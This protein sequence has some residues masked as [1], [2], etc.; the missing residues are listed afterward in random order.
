M[1]CSCVNRRLDQRARRSEG[2]EEAATGAATHR[3]YASKH[4]GVG[5]FVHNPGFKS[6]MRATLESLSFSRVSVTTAVECCY[7]LP[8][9]HC[10]TSFNDLFTL[11]TDVLCILMQEADWC[12]LVPMV[13]GFIKPQ[14][15][16][17]NTVPVKPASEQGCDTSPLLLA[18]LIT[19]P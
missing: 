7:F 14:H 18:V 11:L 13:V 19:Q 3:H 4:R 15:N 8:Q 17:D 16:T 12:R 1:R 5:V 9:S 2:T 6:H 10:N